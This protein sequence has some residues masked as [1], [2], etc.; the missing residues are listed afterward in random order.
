[1]PHKDLI[2]TEKHTYRHTKVA[3]VL[4]RDLREGAVFGREKTLSDIRLALHSNFDS[5]DFRVHNLLELRKLSDFT[6]GISQWL[7]SLATGRPIPL[8]VALY[9]SS[10]EI[11]RLL[12]EIRTGEYNVIYLDSVRCQLLA[13]RLLKVMPSVRLIV[14]FDDLMSRRAVEHVR[15]RIPMSLGFLRQLFPAAL[16][17]IITGPLSRLLTS[18][19]AYSLRRAELEIASAADAIVLVSSVERTILLRTMTNIRHAQIHALP[20]PVRISRDAVPVAAPY[21]FV[22][23]GSDQLVQNRLSIDHLLDTWRQLKPDSELHIYGKQTRTPMTLPNVHWHGFVKDLEDVYTN[24]SIMALPVIMAGGIKSKV[25]E[26][27]SYGCPVLGN[28]PAFEGIDIVDYPLTIPL[29]LWE[30]HIMDPAAFAATW[31]LAARH[32]NEFARTA[33]SPKR[34]TDAWRDVIESTLKSSAYSQG[35]LSSQTQ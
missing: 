31:S 3:L 14:D 20:P 2:E 11:R 5:T 26:A 9:S 19:E 8:Q 28:P 12:G 7:F 23:I 16:Q 34:Y 30:Q 18:Y 13:R 4:T 33:L 24:G 15:Q 10:S 29:H 1:M 21:R 35:T 25:A 6:L 22:F 32:G 27:W 17:R